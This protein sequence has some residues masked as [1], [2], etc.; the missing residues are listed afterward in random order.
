[1]YPNNYALGLMLA[2]PSVPN[3]ILE[4]QVSINRPTIVYNFILYYYIF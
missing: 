4:Y 3:E 2:T 1:M